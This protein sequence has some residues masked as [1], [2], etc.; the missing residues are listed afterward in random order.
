M[1]DILLMEVDADLRAARLSAFWQRWRLPLL[2][3]A[4]ALV[5]GTAAHSL[6]Q[7]WQLRA[8]QAR[9]ARLSAAVAELNAG[10]PNEA[11]KSFA[12]IAVDAPASTRPLVL[13]WQARALSAAKKP[14]EAIRALL[15][16]TQPM[17]SLWADV[18]CLRLVG[19]APE[20][21]RCLSVTVESPLASLRERWRIAQAWQ[22]G[23]AQA[24]SQSVKLRENLS[25][26]PAAAEEIRGWLAVME[27][28]PQAGTAASPVNA[29]PTP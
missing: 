25:L 21:A 14:A 10:R 22:Q 16:A 9:Y 27:A 7:G 3:A 11:A 20:Q 4:V 8:A 28:T 1:T 15:A 26:P 17:G 24:L 29:T 19:L 18:A 13:L 12:A 23:D 2:V 6:Y 5:V